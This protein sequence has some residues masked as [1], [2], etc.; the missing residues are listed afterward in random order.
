MIWTDWYDLTIC[1]K[2]KWLKFTK[3]RCPIVSLL[4]SSFFMCYWLFVL[5]LFV[6]NSFEQ[7]VMFIN[8]GIFLWHYFN[9]GNGIISICPNSTQY[10]HFRNFSGQLEPDELCCNASY[11]I[12]WKMFD[13]T[14]NPHI[15]IPNCHGLWFYVLLFLH[16]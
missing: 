8:S 13:K 10:F 14:P 1:S 9:K 12:M 3:F 16:P 11:V 7:V 2:I 15:I 6:A 5:R 4:Q